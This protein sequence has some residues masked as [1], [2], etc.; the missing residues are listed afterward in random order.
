MV[1]KLYK[2]VTAQIVDGIVISFGQSGTLI[3]GPSTIPLLAPHIP[4][5]QLLMLDNSA[6]ETKYSLAIVFLPSW[7]A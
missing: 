2:I 6:F 5:E 7:M 1:G 3:V 4:L